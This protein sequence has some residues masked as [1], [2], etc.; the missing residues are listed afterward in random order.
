MKR[1]ENKNMQ[2]WLKEHGIEANVKYIS[3]GSLKGLWSIYNANIKWFGN[4]E[5]I[6]KFNRMGFRDHDGDMLNNNSGNGGA[7][8][9][10]SQAPIELNKKCL[11]LDSEQNMVKIEGRY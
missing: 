5:L 3:N 7:F 4:E 6:N 10:F 11:S 8:S 2:Q 9:I 1:I